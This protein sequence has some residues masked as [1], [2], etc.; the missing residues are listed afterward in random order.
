MTT[1]ETHT[2][3]YDIWSHVTQSRYAYAICALPIGKIKI[4]IGGYGK[5]VIPMLSAYLPVPKVRLLIHRILDSVTPPTDGFLF[6]VI[7]GS[8]RDGV[9]ESRILK[10]VFDAGQNGQFATMPWRIV[11]GIGPGKLLDTGGISPI[12]K[13]TSVA[14]I[15]LSVDDMTML[16]LELQ[17]HLAHRQGSYE[18]HRIREQ[19][20]RHAQRTAD[21]DAA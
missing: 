4:A 13:P 3:D 12:G 20:E 2:P 16:A 21:T 14:D 18:Y 1:H 17:A 8:S 11:I 5:K 10:F 15:R 19:R 6:E 9:V 7:G